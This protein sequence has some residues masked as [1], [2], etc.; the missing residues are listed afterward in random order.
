MNRVQSPADYIRAQRAYA[1]QA[2][3]A[4]AHGIHNNCGESLQEI[5]K[6]HVLAAWTTR[7]YYRH[8]P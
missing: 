4:I 6:F 3:R 8:H 2:K 1:R 5:R 7:Q